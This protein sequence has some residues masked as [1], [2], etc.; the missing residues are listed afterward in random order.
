M[1]ITKE[2]PGTSM[3]KASIS[4]GGAVLWWHKKKCPEQPAFVRRTQR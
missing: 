4:A 3:E 2:Y 1:P